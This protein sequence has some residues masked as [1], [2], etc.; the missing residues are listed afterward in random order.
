LE[1]TLCAV[2]GFTVKEMNTMISLAEFWR[3]VLEKA[4][5]GGTKEHF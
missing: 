5:A 1:P 4:R 2:K 3:E